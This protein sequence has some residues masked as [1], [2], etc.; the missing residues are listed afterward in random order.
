MS[1]QLP[2]NRPTTAASLRELELNAPKTTAKEVREALLQAAQKLEDWERLAQDAARQLEEAANIR[3]S[4]M[5]STSAV[6]EIQRGVKSTL[7]ELA[8]RFRE[9]A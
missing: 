5:A 9:Q 8:R 3:I 7:L 1:F 6:N 4:E 2:A